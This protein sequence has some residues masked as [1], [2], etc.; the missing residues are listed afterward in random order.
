[1]AQDFPRGNGNGVSGGGGSNGGGGGDPIPLQQAQVP[2]STL[3]WAGVIIGLLVLFGILSFGRGVYTDLIWFESLGFRPVFVKVTVTRIALF[4]IGTISTAIVLSAS[5]WVAHRYSAGE[6]NLPLPDEMAQSLKRAVVWGAVVI[7]IVLS[8][9]FGSVLAARWELFLRFTNSVPFGQLD[10]VY[11]RDLGFFIFNLPMYTFIQGWIMGIGIVTLLATVAMNFV[12]HSLRGVGYEMTGAR[13]VHISIIAAAIMFTIAAGHW[14]DRWALVLSEDGAGFG[15]M[16][17]DLSARQPALLIMTIVAVAAAVMMLVNIY[18]KQTRIII[19]AVVLWVALGLALNT[20]WPAVIQQFSVTPNEFARESQ[21][22]ARNIQFTRQGFALDRIE[23]QDHLAESDVNPELINNNLQ[24]INNIRLWDYRPLSLVYK[25]IQLIRLYYDFKD[26]DVDRYHIGGEYRQV[27][28]SAREVAPE[29]L[30][31][32]SQTWVN[33]KLFYTHGIG[34]AMS[35]VTEFTPEGRPEF[36]A[37]DIP[38]DG[39][40]PIG[41]QDGTTPPELTVDNPRIYYGENTLEYVIV[42]SNTEELDYQTEGGELVRTRYAGNGGV[43]L[44]SFTRRLAF[45][46]QFGD[47]N[48]LI[49]GEIT[50]NSRLQYR[51]HIQERVSQVAPFLQLD[52]DPYIVAANGQL[53]WMQDA[54]TTTDHYPYSEPTEISVEGSE[55]STHFN[56]MRNSVKVVVDAY[57][58]DIQ[59]YVWDTEDPMILTY[60]RIFPD[61]FTSKEEMPEQLREHTRYPQD[62]FSEQAEKYVKYHMQ[63]PQNFYNN[64]DLWAIPNEK[65]GQG[66][67]LQEVEPY[68]VIMRMPG[69]ATEEFMLLLPYTPSKRQ[70]LIGWIG[71]RSDGDNYGKLVAFNFPKDRQVDG[72]EQVEARIDNDQDISAWFTLRCAEGSTCLRGNLLVIPI[73]TSLLYAEPV[74][75]QAEGV[76]FPQLKRVILAT[77]DKVVMEDSLGLAL[78][79]LTG[80][81]SLVSVGES[82]AAR[83]P[84]GATTAAGTTAG[85][86]STVIEGTELEIQITILSDS[87]ESMKEDLTALEEALEKLKEITGGQ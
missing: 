72:P 30:E 45:A 33:R 79:A 78:A 62:F 43:K 41:L 27:L 65:F 40:I 85:T 75:I 3:K 82:G 50:P 13:L 20:A 22:I 52:R 7:I 54:Y 31:A 53:F 15:A 16:Y 59:F 60:E 51:R 12:N 42:N 25:Q 67:D 49:S 64:E 55:F 26:A 34:I 32:E 58:G 46:W 70:N 23:E 29:R 68:Y 24:T 18:L 47:V 80:E 19:G 17:T 66:D 44:E 35:P 5:L 87:I 6:V 84:S 28:L 81:R 73:G 21:Y 69:E 9:I 8:L 71:A 2:T 39:A 86:T 77:A 38:A 48:I 57:N 56:Y 4:A 10:P 63:D 1:M 76:P 36:F 83:T 14:F 11:G 61:L 74:Y 37:K